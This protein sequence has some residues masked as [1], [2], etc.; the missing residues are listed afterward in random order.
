MPALNW[1]VD[2]LPNFTSFFIVIRH[3]S[4]AKFKL[5]HFLRW[6][7]EPHQS[8]NFETFKC[9]GEN[10][11]TSSCYFWKH[12]SKRVVGSNFKKF[13]SFFKQQIVFSSNFA[14]TLHG[15]SNK[16]SAKKVQKSYL[17]WHWGVIQSLKKL[18]CDFKYDI[19]SFVNFT[20]SL[21]TPEISLWRAIFV[22]T[23]WDLI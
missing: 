15:T 1:L 20:Q 23:I 8:P 22:R 2:S 6:I 5:I 18:T 21:K 9:S 19:R 4:P 17:S 11:P 10:L 12:N 7:E 3:N 14:A 16:V 13:L